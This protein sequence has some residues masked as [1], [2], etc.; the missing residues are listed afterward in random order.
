MFLCPGLLWYMGVMHYDGW[1]ADTFAL[2]AASDAAAQGLNPY[3]PNPLDVF[4]RPHVYSHWWL[5]LHDAGLTRADISWLGPL[6]VALFFI[7]ALLYLRPRNR[8]QWWFYFALLVSPPLLLA[9]DRANND[10]IV[11]ILLT[12]LVPCLRHVRTG[13]RF[14]AP[15]LVALVAGLKYFPAAAGLA[16]LA[17]APARELRW[18][19][20]LGIVLLVI[21]GISVAPDLAMFSAI[22]P[23][24]YGWASFGAG[25]FFVTLGWDG[26][27]PKVVLVV[28]A[29]ALAMVAGRSRRLAGWVPTPGEQDDWLRFVVGGAMLTGCF[30]ASTNFSYRWVFALWLAPLIWNLAHD[31][32]APATARR[33]ARLSQWLLLAA[34]WLDTCFT[35]IV[36]L[37]RG[38]LTQAFWL[39]W[40]KW[41]YLAEQ[42]LTWAFFACVLI[43]LVHFAKTGLRA[44]RGN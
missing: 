39:G 23:K 28:A 5:H 25:N 43:F 27:M 21:T 2:L 20:A 32:S 34:L 8:G 22:A 6:V 17:S 11:F 35:W 18:R 26:T 3:L 31:S 16:L 37:G 7:S 13:V 44:L 41:S 24:P 1:Y 4:N 15:L 12:P 19:L 14:M 36:F 29:A 40:L 38:T 10:L 33:L 30:F 9:L 42:P